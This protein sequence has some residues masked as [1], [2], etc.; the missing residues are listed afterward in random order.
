M[1]EDQICSSYG[2]QVF[3]SDCLRLWEE[4]GEYQSNAGA[5]ARR[6]LERAAL[7]RFLVLGLQ[8]TGQV[9]EHVRLL[10]RH[11]KPGTICA[12]DDE[13]RYRY[14]CSSRGAVRA[15]PPVPMCPQARHYG[16]PYRKNRRGGIPALRGF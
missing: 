9:V 1:P 2:E 8:K 10:S 6:S 13:Y 7:T 3:P 15:C 5:V 12:T 4:V 11:L 14:I 16:L